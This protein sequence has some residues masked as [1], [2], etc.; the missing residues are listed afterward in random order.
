[1]DK[2]I[3]W[4]DCVVGSAT[5]NSISEAEDHI[6]CHS[7]KGVRHGPI[8]RQFHVLRNGEFVPDS[9]S[10]IPDAFRGLRNG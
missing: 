10:N 2:S 8:T 4:R 9:N 1:M 7:E 3:V 6:N 5:D